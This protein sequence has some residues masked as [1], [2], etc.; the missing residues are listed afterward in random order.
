M[1]EDALQVLIK[2][3]GDQVDV[4]QGKLAGVDMWGNRRLGY[5]VSYRGAHYPKGFYIL[6]TYLGGGRTVAEFERTIRMLEDIMRYQTVKMEEGVDPASITEVLQTRQ[7]DEIVAPEPVFSQE[8]EREDEVRVDPA[9]PEPAPAA[10][11]APETAPAPV[12]AVPETAPAP[13]AAAPETAPA[14]AEPEAKGP[15]EEASH[16]QRS[17]R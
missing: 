12:A 14:P 4:N 17:E 3:L 5:P 7:R 1:P 10:E 6:F 15:E 9:R 8:E 11:A 16:E 2:R 13:A